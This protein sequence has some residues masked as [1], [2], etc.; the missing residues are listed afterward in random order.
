VEGT[1]GAAE[2]GVVAA[3]LGFF[4]IDLISVTWSFGT[5]YKYIELAVTRELE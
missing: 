2:D 3:V 4:R 5:V 1:S